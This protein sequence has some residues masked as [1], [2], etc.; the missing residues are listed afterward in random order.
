V[1]Q[2]HFPDAVVKTRDDLQRGGLTEDCP[3]ANRSRGLLSDR[4]AAQ[5]RVQEADLAASIDAPGTSG[6]ARCS[7]QLLA[8]VYGSFAI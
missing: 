5:D 4:H 2:T 8:V 6:V 1:C 3:I 7:G